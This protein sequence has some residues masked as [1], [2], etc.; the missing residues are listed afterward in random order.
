MLRPALLL[1]FVLVL[2]AS[3]GPTA[4][5]T[6]IAALTD[7]RAAVHEPAIERLIGFG[8]AALP[9]VARLASDADWRVRAR[10]ITVAAAIGGPTAVPVVIAAS[11]DSE[12]RVRELAALGLGA[13]RDE[14]VYQRLLAL[15]RDRETAVRIAAGRGLVEFGDPRALAVLAD[16]ASELDTTAR[17]ER[18]V[19]L[20]R[21]AARPEVVPALVELLG[22][23]TGDVLL[24]L[25]M[26]TGRI[27]DPRLSPPLAA[28][29]SSADREVAVLAAKSLAVNGDSR[30]LAA[31]CPAAAGKVRDLAQAAAATLRT[32]TGFNAAPGQAWTVWWRDHAAEAGAV[33]ERDAFIAAL[34]DPAYAVTADELARFT[35]EQL[36]PLVDGVQG[37]GAWWW[38]QRSAEV[39]LRDQAARWTAPLLARIRATADPEARLELILLLDQLGDPAAAPGLAALLAEHRAALAALRK[40]GGPVR[41]DPTGLALEAAIARRRGGILD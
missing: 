3:E 10:V 11:H 17:R 18:G 22:K 33:A 34:H 6:S 8:A 4:W 36:M 27:G 13:L 16:Y 19:G 24:R 31:L 20:E 38:P 29:L 12:P 30:A 14:T 9:D 41:N 32:L 2:P 15:L 21:L 37:D 7:P 1:L 35:P 28:L 5:E 39:L 25:V 23:A 40:Q 26:A